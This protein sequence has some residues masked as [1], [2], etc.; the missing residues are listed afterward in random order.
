METPIHSFANFLKIHLKFL[1]HFDRNLLSSYFF[2]KVSSNCKASITP[3]R[4]L[5]HCK[6]FVLMLQASIGSEWQIRTAMWARSAT[7]VVYRWWAVGTNR[8][9]W[10]TSLRWVT[11]AWPP[12]PW[13]AGGPAVPKT[14]SA[15]ASEKGN[16]SNGN[17]KALNHKPKVSYVMLVRQWVVLYWWRGKSFLP[18]R[19]RIAT[20]IPLTCTLDR[21]MAFNCQ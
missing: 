8:P 2:V 20:V 17:R 21:Q 14:T 15:S 18:F 3:E 6:Q 16:N 9:A 13:I 11:T 7:W 4:L 1:I 5:M 19:G 10:P 12:H